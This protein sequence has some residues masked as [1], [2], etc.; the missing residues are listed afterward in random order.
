MIELTDTLV[1]ADLNRHARV[2]RVAHTHTLRKSY[3]D[4]PFA[5]INRKG[6]KIWFGSGWGNSFADGPYDTYQIDLPGT[7]YEDLMGSALRG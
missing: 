3:A 6:T 1:N 2:W 4:D 7:W 5:K